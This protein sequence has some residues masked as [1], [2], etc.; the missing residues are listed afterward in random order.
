MNPRLAPRKLRGRPAAEVTE[1][2]Q[3][4]VMQKDEYVKIHDLATGKRWVERGPQTIFL[5]PLW[6]VQ[7][8]RREPLW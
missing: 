5:E 8:A 6:K 4:V 1:K 2:R 7:P 3:A